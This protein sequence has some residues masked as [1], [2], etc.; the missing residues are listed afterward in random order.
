ME[1]V[2]KLDDNNEQKQG[3]LERIET[4]LTKQVE[5]DLEDVEE[6]SYIFDY[7]D[8]LEL[9]NLL[10]DNNP[11]KEQLLKRLEECQPAVN[12]HWKE[13]LDWDLEVMTENN[14]RYLNEYRMEDFIESINRGFDEQSKLD[15]M[16]IVDELKEKL[17]EKNEKIRNIWLW[18]L[19]ISYIILL[20]VVLQKA[21]KLIKERN[22]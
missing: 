6:H 1:Y 12:K 3:Y 10:K 21:N 22:K 7:N 17:E 19:I 16:L 2:N 11:K 20:G 4:A 15:Y 14:Y 18:I 8:A 13:S 9:I 5:I